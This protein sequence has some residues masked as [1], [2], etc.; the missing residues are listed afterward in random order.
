MLTAVPGGCDAAF[1]DRREA[2]AMKNCQEISRL[3]SDGLDGELGWNQK[4]AL[5]AHLLMCDGCS[6]FASQLN[7]LRKVSRAFVKHLDRSAGPRNG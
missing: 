5:R 2:R 7:T 1:V 6:S 3:I 4:L